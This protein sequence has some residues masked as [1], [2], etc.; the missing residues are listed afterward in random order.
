MVYIAIDYHN[1]RAFFVQAYNIINI[2][3]FNVVCTLVGVIKGS[4]NC[5]R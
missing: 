3:A 2:A 5:I 1:T 4:R